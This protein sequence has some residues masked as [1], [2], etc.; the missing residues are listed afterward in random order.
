MAKIS[1]IPLVLLIVI[2]FAGTA[3]ADSITGSTVDW[4]Y[5]AYG[6]AYTENG[7]GGTSSGS[8]VV[9]CMSCG[10]FDGY[11]LIDSSANSITFDYSVWAGSLVSW[12]SSALSLTPEIYNGIDLLFSGGPAIT[13]V[14]VDPA[15]NMAGFSASNVYFTGNEIQV[16]WQ[17]LPF[18]SSTIV[19]LDVNGTT[20]PEPTSLFL[21]GTGVVGIGLAAWRRKKT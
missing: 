6:A 13:S 3:L 15:T 2:G 19:T 10:N 9:P 16:D 4:Q 8:F 17:D 1:L 14:T 5:Y 12:A 7:S 18:S 11:F 20:V 21:L